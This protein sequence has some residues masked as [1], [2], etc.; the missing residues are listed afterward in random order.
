MANIVRIDFTEN[1]LDISQAEVKLRS[2]TY[3]EVREAL[4]VAWA[5]VGEA[6]AATRQEAIIKL[7]ESV[8][9]DGTDTIIDNVEYVV[10]VSIINAVTAFLAVPTDLR[11]TNE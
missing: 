3:G 2:A 10:A 1:A 9:I 5:P 7:I 6:T 11:Q 8:S 4:S